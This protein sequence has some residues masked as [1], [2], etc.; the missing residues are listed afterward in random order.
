MAMGCNRCLDSYNVGALQLITLPSHDCFC[1]QL[2]L[3]ASVADTLLLLLL[4]ERLSR[5]V[6]VEV[7]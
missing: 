5:E 4:L 7:D 1:R 2:K 6:C 3:H